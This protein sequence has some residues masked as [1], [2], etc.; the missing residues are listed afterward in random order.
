MCWSATADLAAGSGVAAVGVA[1]VALVR[2][3]REL[4]LAA[5][6]LLLGVHQIVESVVWRSGGGGGGPATVVWAVIALPLLAVWVPAGVMWVAPPHAR[7]RL[8]VP[9]AA[10]SLTAV[11]LARGLATGPVT[12]EIHGHTLAYVL[13]VSPVPLLVIGY[14]LGTVGS[15]LLSGDRWLLVLGILV[16]VG[17]SACWVLWRL[18]F[19][20]TWCAVAALCS[21]VLF[22]WMRA[23]RTSA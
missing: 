4:P 19:V 22:G 8:V 17:A 18:A 10:G 16:A 14:L 6:P 3:G 1:C 20:S 9:L 13:H 15:L 12:A 23:R 7:F 2:Q 5:M 21:V 11:S